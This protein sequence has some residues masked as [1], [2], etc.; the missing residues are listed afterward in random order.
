MHKSACV[1]ELC[2]RGVDQDSALTALQR[3]DA[4]LIA[5]YGRL[6]AAWN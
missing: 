2:A 4:A 3:Q 5:R 1:C 6:A